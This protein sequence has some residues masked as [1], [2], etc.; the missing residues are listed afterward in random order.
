MVFQVPA[1]AADEAVDFAFQV[2][3]STFRVRKAKFLDVDT[4][5]TLET[6]GMAALAF[7]KG[8]T[9]AQRKA[10]GALTRDQFVALLAGWYEDSEVS[11]GESEASAS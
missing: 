6:D 1:I 7:F 3:K 4:L 11:M 5:E 10:V 8:S 2:G 9:Q